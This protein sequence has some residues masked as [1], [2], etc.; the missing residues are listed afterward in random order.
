MFEANPVLVEVTRAGFVESRHRGACVVVDDKGHIVQ[1]WGDVE[2]LVYP[3]SALKPLQALPLIESGAADHYGLSDEEIALA[4]AS[5][6]SQPFH[7]SRIQT[8]LERLGLNGDDLEC[9]PGEPISLDVS[10]SL[11]KNGESLTRIHNNCSGKHAGFLTT[12]LHLGVPTENYIKPDHPVQQR[13]KQVVEDMTGVSLD[14]LPCGADGCGIPVYAFPLKALATGMGRMMD[15][16]LSPTRVSAAKRVRAAMAAHPHCIAGGKRFDTRVMTATK[17]AVLVK[18]GAEGVHIAMIPDRKL[19][20]ALKVDDGA[21]RASE[22]VMGCVLDGLGF[23]DEKARTV[24]ADLIEMPINT[25]LGDRAG[26]IRRGS[27]LVF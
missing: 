5:H 23:L 10:K 3:R 7:T 27:G 20:I 2:A 24:L 1:S 19:A 6:N 25:T 17:G 14:T 16:D 4:C 21:I 26:E 11:S 8:W 15:D 13:I 22:L 9:G 18:G 12:A